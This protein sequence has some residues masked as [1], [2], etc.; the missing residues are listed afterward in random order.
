MSK[1]L[2]QGLEIMLEALQLQFLKFNDRLFIAIFSSEVLKVLF[3]SVMSSVVP[4]QYWAGD[5]DKSSLF[6]FSLCLTIFDNRELL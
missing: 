1:L 5:I 4:M 2:E 6:N 3:C